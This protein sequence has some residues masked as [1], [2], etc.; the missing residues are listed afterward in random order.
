MP[1]QVT[2][3]CRALLDEVAVV[4]ATAVEKA[5]S[6]L[7]FG[8]VVEFPVGL[9]V[10]CAG[11]RVRGHRREPAVTRTDLAWAFIFGVPLLALGLLLSSWCGR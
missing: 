4:P 3:R 2:Q 9:G 10:S 1:R 8:V 5:P 6:R 11:R 7:N